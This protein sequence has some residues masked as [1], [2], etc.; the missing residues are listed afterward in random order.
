MNTI[1]IRIHKVPVEAYLLNKNLCAVMFS[2]LQKQ[3]E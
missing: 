3:R 2:A 1:C